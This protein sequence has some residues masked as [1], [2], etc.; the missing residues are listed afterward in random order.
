MTI[1]QAIE[2]AIEGGFRVREKHVDVGAS[3]LSTSININD[4]LL[5]F[6]FWQ[7][8]GKSM[9]WN[10]YVVDER[11]SM[12]TFEWEYHNAKGT[13]T[14]EYYWHKLIDHLAEGGTIEG[15]FKSL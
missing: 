2:K 15:Y 6:S 9:G 1:Q 5:D 11:P 14:P 7:A 8:L 4:V 10:T 13:K 12:S 3:Q